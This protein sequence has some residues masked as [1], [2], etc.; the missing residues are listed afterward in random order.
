MDG[1]DLED[2]IFVVG[3]GQS[4]TDRSDALIIKKSGDM[5]VEGNQIKNLQDPTDA[6]DAATKAYVDAQSSA[7]GLMNFNGWENYEIWNEDTTF[8]L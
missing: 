6:Q 3:N 8:Q 4:D 1:Y 5:S 7:Q 2:R